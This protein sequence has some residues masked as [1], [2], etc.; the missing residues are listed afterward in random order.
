MT[1]TEKEF[2]IVRCTLREVKAYDGSILTKQG[3]PA[4]LGWTPEGGGFPEVHGEHDSAHEFK[5]PPTPETI[6]RW[7]GMPW[8]SRIEPGSAR[9]L[10]VREVRTYERT[11]EAVP[12][13]VRDE[14]D[15]GQ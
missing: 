4:V 2:Y 9:V 7:D 6:A 3:T 1:R 8:Y 14:K 10:K 13:N 5:E 15:S 11:E 12:L